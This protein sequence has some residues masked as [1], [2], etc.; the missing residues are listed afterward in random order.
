MS[1]P[2]RYMHTNITARDWRALAAFY[3]EVLE[4]VPASAEFSESRP[5][6]A[7]G[8]GAPG[9]RVEG[10][11]LRLPGRGQDGPTIELYGFAPIDG[12]PARGSVGLGIGHLAFEVDDVRAAHERVLAAGGSA[13]GEVVDADVPGR[14]RICFV[15]VR[16]PEGNIIELQSWA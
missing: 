4:C 11:H 10:I 2:T 1:V 6:L 9:A 15:Y 12:R 3:V 5:W 7:Q 16:D 8:T 14:G 13:L